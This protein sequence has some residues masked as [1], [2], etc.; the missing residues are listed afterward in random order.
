MTDNRKR[1][2]RSQDD[3]MITGL[4]GGI[5]EAY[6]FDPSMIRILTL[7]IV[8]FTFPIGLVAYFAAAL[9]VPSEDKV[10]GQPTLE[11]V[12]KEETEEDEE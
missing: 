9:L 4:C 12:E 11:D 2:Y 6:S 5:A 8:I 7:L 10:N 3:K 1:V